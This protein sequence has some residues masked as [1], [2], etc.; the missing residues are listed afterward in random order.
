MTN[1]EFK[2]RLR[3]AGCIRTV[4]QRHQI[5]LAATL[6]QTDTYFH[7]PSGRLKLREIDG[8]AAQLIFYQRPD[9]AAIKR[10]DYLIAPVAWPAA[11]REALAAA[12]GIRSVVKKVRELYWLP[13][14]FGA[15][16]GRAAPN[17]IRLHLDDVEERGHFLEIEVILQKGE[18]SQLAE[19]EAAF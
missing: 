18:S 3:N 6:R 19:R 1:L 5:P 16:A 14:K 11:L 9:R 7:V 8:E 15:H 13:R 2:A 17:L 4:L 10:S 12:Y